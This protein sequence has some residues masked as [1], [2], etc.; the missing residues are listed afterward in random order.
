[1]LAV[2]LLA[3]LTL[4]GQLS[5]LDGSLCLVAFGLAMLYLV[6]LGRRGK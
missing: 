6:R 4:D 3:V 5:C 1:M 2:V